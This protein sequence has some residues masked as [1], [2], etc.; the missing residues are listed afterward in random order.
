YTGNLFRISPLLFCPPTQG[1]LRR[2]DTPAQDADSLPLPIR[3]EI[4]GTR[5]FP[6][7][8]RRF[9][10]EIIRIDF[11]IDLD[12]AVCLGPCVPLRGA[13]LISANEFVKQ[14]IF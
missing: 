2:Y 9:E 11:R 7:A 13:D 5:H 14:V 4:V 3:Q 8:C 10:D 12:V 6:A 1:A